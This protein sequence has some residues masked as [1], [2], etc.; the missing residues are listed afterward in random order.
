MVNINN[1]DYMTN[2]GIYNFFLF[3]STLTR[4]LVEVFSVIFLYNLGY[5]VNNIFL[6]LLVMYIFGIIV[7]YFSLIINKKQVLVIS[8]VLYGISYLYLSFMSCNIYNLIL[9][10]ILLS[11][12]SYSYHTVRHYL[13]MKM[14][15]YDRGKNI[16]IILLVMYGALILSNVIGI[17]LVN[18]LSI[19]INS[20]IIMVL[21]MISI[22]PILK[23]EGIK[24]QKV[25]FKDINI[26]KDKIMF[27]IL[28]QFKVILMEIQPLYV[29]LYINKSMYY[30]GI[31]NIIINLASLIV[32]LFITKKIGNNHFKY[33]NLL[34]CIV[35][36]FKLNMSDNILLF[37]I[38][39]LEGIGMKVYEKFSLD[40]LYDLDKNQ[41]DSYLLLEELIF[42]GSKSIIMAIFFFFIRDIRVILYICIIGI[43]VSAFYIKDKD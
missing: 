41:V 16:N 23:L 25:S 17:F 42:F 21:S 14:V 9:F 24:E 39:F 40:N 12:S 1:G 35:L 8:T 37:L 4:G 29:Y 26:S 10:A 6:F 30:V 27:S 20:S 36:V 7:N 22:I 28:E 34:L 11:F 43:F 19:T 38:A 18:K 33:I 2:K 15:D 31:F 3:M 32:M 5:S 13:A